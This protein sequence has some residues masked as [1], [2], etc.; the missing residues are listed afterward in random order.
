M[1]IKAQRF[2]SLLLVSFMILLPG[3]RKKSDRDFSGEVEATQIDI[4]VKLAGRIE[5]ILVTEGQDVSKDTPLGILGSP[6]IRAKMQ[7]AQAGGGEATEQLRLA[8]T[9]YERLSRLLIE[10]AVTQQQVDEARYKLEASRQKVSATAG[11]IG[12]IEA[13]LDETHIKAPIDGEIASIVSN[14][15]ELVAPGYPVITMIDLNDQWVTFNVRE[16]RLK[17]IKKGAGAKVHVPAID[18]TIDM[19]VTY[20]SS[21]G[22]FAKWRSTS[23]SGGFDIKTFEVRVRPLGPVAG[24]RPGM[25]AL[26]K[27]E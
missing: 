17:L 26:V 6:E 11:T 9:T 20:I 16:D 4:G 19:K 25:S 12:E 14:A 7:S 18:Q 8:Q 15:G 5:K 23:E 2:A 21:L 13:A 1:R 24:L 27:I 10:G 22:A 3:C